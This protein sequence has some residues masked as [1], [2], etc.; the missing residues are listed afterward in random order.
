MCVEDAAY[1]GEKRADAYFYQSWKA[2]DFFFSTDFGN[3]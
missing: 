2:K 1:G 3:F